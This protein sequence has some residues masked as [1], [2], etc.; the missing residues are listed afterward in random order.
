MARW[1]ILLIVAITSILGIYAIKNT[2]YAV[3][4]E[5]YFPRESPEIKFYEAYKTE[6]LDS[7]AL[8]IIAVKTHAS[9][10]SPTVIKSIDNLTDSILAL[11]NV[12]RVSSITNAKFLVQTSFMG[13]VSFPYVHPDEPQ[14]AITDSA[15]IVQDQRMVGTLIASDLKGFSIHVF[16]K[17]QL[18]KEEATLFNDN[19]QRLIVKG[20]FNEFHLGGRILGERHILDTLQYEM[21]LFTLLAAM[22]VLLVLGFLYKTVWGLLGPLLVIGI[23]TIWTLGIMAI[24]N[25]PLGIFSSIVPAILFVIGTSDVVHILHKYIDAIRLGNTKSDSLRIAYLEVGKAT[26]LTTVTTM[27]GFLTLLS[28][29]IVPVREFGVYTA[30][31]VGIAF[32]LTY[33]LYPAF[34]ILTPIPKVATNQSGEKSNKALLWVYQLTQTKAKQIIV[35]FLVLGFVGLWTSFQLKAESFLTEELP[36]SHPFKKGEKYIETN[37]SGLRILELSISLSDSSLNKTLLSYEVLKQ[38]DTLED[39]AKTNYSTQSVYSIASLVRSVHEANTANVSNK[40][41]PTVDEFTFLKRDLNRLLNTKQSASIWKKSGEQTRMTGMLPDVGGF[42]TK[43]NN[44]SLMRFSNQHC[45]DLNVVITGMSHLHDENNQ[46]IVND[47]II[48]L[49]IAFFLVSL[50]IAFVYKSFKLVVIALIPNILPLLLITC[51]MFALNI[52]LNVSTALI[53]AIAFGIAVDDTI[54]FL[55]RVKMELDKGQE[56][57]A[58]TKVA[59]LTTGRSIVITSVILFAGFMVLTFSGLSSTYNF[60]VLVSLTI[61]F[62]VFTD[63]LL[64][65]ILLKWF[66]HS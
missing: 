37:Y 17:Y 24:F 36:D 31:G 5:R 32:V 51:V 62:A 59:F 7:N 19:L 60:G 47:M 6:F 49:C 57:P 35:L 44:D 54:H 64:L 39:Y 52:N 40:E 23:T 53:F 11:Q 43:Q 58:A 27:I 63:L 13:L 41:F 4:L 28:S 3:D 42:A 45:P 61:L 18:T 26:L 25:T 8:S 29:G 9:V 66:K 10:F 46:R 12:S 14:L 30:I 34:L 16:T 15:Y 2:K 55:S 21:V 48:G 33:T 50:L 22:V 38:I 65:P 20:G 56:L 1:T